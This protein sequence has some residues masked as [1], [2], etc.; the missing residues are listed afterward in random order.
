LDTRTKIVQSFDNPQLKTIIGYFDPMHAGHVRRLQELCP[1]GQRINVL[2][3]DPPEPILPTRARAE[4]VAALAFVAEVSTGQ[5][6]AGPNVIDERAA[7]ADRGRVFAQH[8]LAR[9]NT[10]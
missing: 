9:H 10:K 6:I 1:D 2:V 8:V 3:A 5:A 7:D 4:L